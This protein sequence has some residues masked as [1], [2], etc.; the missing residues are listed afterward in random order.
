MSLGIGQRY[1]KPL[2]VIFIIPSLLKRIYP[3]IKKFL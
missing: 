1:E 2:R 3:Q